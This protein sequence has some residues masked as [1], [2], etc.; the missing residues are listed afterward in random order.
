MMM[1]K[2]RQVMIDVCSHVFVVYIENI[3]KN[4]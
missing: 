4:F 1:M 2:V 3:S